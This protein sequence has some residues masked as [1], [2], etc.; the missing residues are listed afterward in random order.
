MKFRVVWVGSEGDLR[1][2]TESAL[3]P[4]GRGVRYEK[5]GHEM[6]R[7]EQKKVIPVANFHARIVRDV[8]SQSEGRYFGIAADLQGEAVELLVPAA[9]FS[10][11]NWVATHLG[12]RAILHPGQQQHARAAIQY[13]STEIRREQIFAHLGWVNT[14]KDW[15]YLHSD[16][17]I[18]SAGSMPD[19]RVRL[20]AH[21]Q[22]YRLRPAAEGQVVNAVR[23]SLRFLSVAPDRVSLPL[24]AA[25]YRAALG[26]TDFSL[27]LMGLTGSFK[28]ALASL[29]QQHFGASMDAAHLPGNFASTANA[30]EELAFSAKDA[31]LVVDDFVPT[32]QTSDAGLHLL[33]ERVFRSAGNGQ[34]RARIGAH[35]ELQTGRPPRGLVLATGEAVPR[36]Q[37]IRARLLILEVQ[38]GEID[39]TVLSVCQQFGRQGS[40]AAAMYEYIRWVS[41]RYEEVQEALRA[42][43]EE[44]HLVAPNASFTHSRLPRMLK[45]LEGGWLNWLRFALD[46]G[47]ITRIQAGQLRRRAQQALKE[48]AQAQGLYYQ[49]SD[50]ALR[51]VALLRTALSRGAAHVADRSGAP[52]DRPALWGWRAN[53]ASWSPQG[54][55]VGWLASGEVFLDPELSYQVAQVM[56]GSGELSVS[57]QSLRHRL[58]QSKL[59][60]SVEACRQTLYIR[61][62]L[63]GMPRKV[64]HLRAGDL[65]DSHG[66]LRD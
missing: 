5:R 42:H 35:G 32:G 37:S 6:V 56:A 8:T 19:C 23:S 36:G 45:Q 10:R 3:E 59:L 27:F 16:G 1:M 63:D 53:G 54:T 41:Q 61:R 28:T 39:Q 21:L 65:M 22:S 50:P 7:V 66:G 60:V 33:A 38:R 9:E 49:Y 40:L 48:V 47:A 12:P 17:V 2:P 20:P 26:A 24:L 11:M 15:C 30:L 64:L 18:T 29:C 34:G 51:F 25:V 55:R 43:V 31:V 46:I 44:S 57:P 4:G 14:G 52:P 58:H 13:L 62:T